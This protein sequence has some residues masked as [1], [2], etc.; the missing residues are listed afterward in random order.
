VVQNL[1]RTDQAEIEIGRRRL[2]VNLEVAEGAER[3]LLWQRLLV[4]AP[5]FADYQKK[6]GRRIPMAILSPKS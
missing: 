5:F 4:R 6:V 1:R 3:E 2:P